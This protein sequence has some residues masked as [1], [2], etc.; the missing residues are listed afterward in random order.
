MRLDSDLL[1]S[2]PV[3]PSIEQQEHGQFV[4]FEVIH[5]LI[6]SDNCSTRDKACHKHWLG[7]TSHDSNWILQQVLLSTCKIVWQ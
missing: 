7:T 3:K 4:Q 1:L 2:V 5:G 6:E